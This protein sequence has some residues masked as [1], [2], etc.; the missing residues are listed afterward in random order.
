M[1]T[2]KTFTEKEYL[3][4]PI[5][6][7]QNAFNDLLRDKFTD[8]MN[9]LSLIGSCSPKELTPI[10]GKRSFTHQTEW[11]LSVWAVDFEGHT[12]FL[13]SASTKGT[14]VE[15]YGPFANT[16]SFS[17]LIPIAERFCKELAQMIVNSQN[18]SERLQAHIA[19]FNRRQ[20]KKS[21]IRNLFRPK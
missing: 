3:E 12:F 14:S 13:P 7:I 9:L 4:L 5:I 8:A 15:V 17:D 11:N 21:F 20:S 6:E 10:L 1:I 19:T 2:T 16:D 18:P